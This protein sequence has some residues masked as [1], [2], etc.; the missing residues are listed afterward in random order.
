MAQPAQ[1]SFLSHLSPEAVLGTAIAASF[2]V[3]VF[4]GAGV[5]VL[6]KWQRAP[7][8]QKVKVSVVETPKAI[9]PK[10]VEVPKKKVP[11]KEIKPVSERKPDKKVVEQVAPV[12]GLSK[13]SFTD[14]PSNVAVA[15]GNTLLAPDEGKRLNP[16][17]IKALSGED[18][19]SDP[20]LIFATMKTP[21]YTDDA[22]D[23]NLEG[24]FVVDVFVD[25]QGIVQSA[26][27]NKK[28]G[29]GMDERILSAA[30]EAKF[31]PRK[32]RVGNAIEGWTQIKFKLELPR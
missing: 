1:K 12:A 8:P 21:Q 2:L 26:E 20:K 15:A 10:P 28:V 14:G 7:V 29:F 23:A 18:L 13:E 27:L 3:H 17:D 6:D 30:R 19:S 31:V 5:A 22:V 24:L 9:P 25:K 32:D 11:P 16:N 4:M